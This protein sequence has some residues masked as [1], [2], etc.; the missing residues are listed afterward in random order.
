MWSA[1]MCVRK[2]R[3]TE[4]GQLLNDQKSTAIGV[5]ANTFPLLGLMLSSKHTSYSWKSL[6][7]ASKLSSIETIGETESKQHWR[8]EKATGICCVQSGSVSVIPKKSFTNVLYTIIITHSDRSPI[9]ARSAVQ[10]NIPVT[11]WMTTPKR[12]HAALL[13]T[14]V[15]K[16]L[17]M[18]CTQPWP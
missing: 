15:W 14:R 13:L 7:Y 17:S 6:R 10:S 18:L 8:H 3:W 1:C 12:L 9:P 4:D 2:K 16:W 11:S 5:P